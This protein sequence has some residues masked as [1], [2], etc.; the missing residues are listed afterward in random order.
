MRKSRRKRNFR[1]LPYPPGHKGATVPVGAKL[2]HKLRSTAETETSV[3]Q[4][5]K[6]DKRKIQS[7]FT[8]GKVE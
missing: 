3:T 7:I 8:K 4:K 6:T 5:N 2:R 1:I